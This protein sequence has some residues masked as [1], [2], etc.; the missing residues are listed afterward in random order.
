MT[1]HLTTLRESELLP[2]FTMSPQDVTQT[3]TL[4]DE[5]FD[6]LNRVRVTPAVYHVAPGCHTHTHTHTHTHLHTH[7][8]P[9]TDRQE[10]GQPRV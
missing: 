9:E 7:T 6:Y 3:H 2:L 5:A 1:R 8:Q 10:Q 4:D